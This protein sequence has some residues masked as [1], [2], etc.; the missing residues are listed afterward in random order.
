[1][2]KGNPYGLAPNNP[3]FKDLSIAPRTLEN[4]EPQSRAAIYGGELIVDYAEAEL[5]RGPNEVGDD[6]TWYPYDMPRYI[7]PGEAWCSEFVCWVYKVADLGMT[8]GT[9]GG[10]MHDSSYKLEDYFRGLNRWVSA[11]SSASRSIK[12]QIG[13]H[14]RFHTLYVQNVS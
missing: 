2:V 4:L 1:M 7:N 9:E 14:C 13:K 8:G 5:G 3:G 11:S 10:W 6:I 12:T